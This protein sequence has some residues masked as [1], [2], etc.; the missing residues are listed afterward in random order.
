MSSRTNT[1]PH[2]PQRCAQ[3]NKA[4]E[5]TTGTFRD[6]YADLLHDVVIPGAKEKRISAVAVFRLTRSVVTGRYYTRVSKEQTSRGWGRPMRTE[7]MLGGRKPVIRPRLTVAVRAAAVVGTVVAGIAGAAAVSS[8]EADASTG[9]IAVAKSP[10]VESLDWAGGPGYSRYE[11]E[12]E[13]LRNCQQLQRALDC[14][15]L[16][17][18]AN[19]VA[20]A[21]DISEPFNQAYGAIGDTPAIAISMA[22]AAAG[23]FA[24]DPS[25]RCSYLTATN[26]SLY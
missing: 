14:F 15:V 5:L 12:A 22:V 9:W 8:A 24:N 13:A 6:S 11:A 7:S 10:F 2:H 4:A 17:S 21:W 18:G 23:P 26:P 20:V 1:V 16:A 19:C 25:V 3:L